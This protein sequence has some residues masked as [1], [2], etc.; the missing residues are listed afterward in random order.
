[1]I[2]YPHFET[3]C[4]HSLA[5]VFADEDLREEPYRQGSALIGE[6]YSFQVA[7]RSAVHTKVRI[8]ID[9]GLSC[10]ISVRSVGLAPSELPNY[11]D[12]DDYLLRTAPGLYPDPL[13]PLEEE[14]LKV[15]PHQWR[16]LWITVHLSGRV[17]PGIHDIHIGF[18]DESGQLGSESFRLEAI[19]AKLPEQKLIH[20]QWFYLD[21]LATWYDVDVF[22][23]AHWTIIES[24]L[25]NYVEYGM[26]MILT[27]LFTPPLE[28]LPGHERPTVQLVG[29]RTDRNRYV[30]D[31]S[32]L[33]RWIDLCCRKGIQYFEFSHLFT[34]WGAK[35]APKIMAE[36]NGEESRIFGWETDAA[37]EEYSQFLAQFI[38][39]LVHWIRSRGLEK[40]S[41]F[42]LSDEPGLNDLPSY[43]QASKMVRS[44]LEDL[45]ILDALSE[46]DF[47]STGLLTHPVVATGHIERFIENNTPNLWAYYCCNEY[48]EHLSNRFFNMPSS[49]TRMI[50][51]Q[52]YKFGIQGFLHWGYNHWYSQKS[53][54]PINPYQVTD[55][56][57]AFPSGD[58]FLVY[59][60][61]EGPVCSI[62]M[63]VMREAMQ[64]IRALQLLE[65][66]I[67][68]QETVRCLEQDM[69]RPITFKDYEKRS[70]WMIEMRERVNR[71]IKQYILG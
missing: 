50:G 37:G 28:M 7:Y 47:Y 71:M 45:P 35:H 36:V 49:R 68:K 33:E 32:R 5:K 62:R 54:K 31:F 29:V 30:F 48:R 23:E 40:R 20:T 8:S 12:H 25:T 67:G 2:H 53:L 1:M 59:P 38:P 70:D 17:T 43:T 55:A 65:G 13:Y 27:P 15:P 26:N 44:L 66:L 64:D 34:Q 4:I 6:Y 63:A 46:Y 14:S 22:S 41:Y 56:D 10:D 21:C 11:Q 39:E 58:A 52:L 69:D 57:M 16:S 24:Y 60:G 42:H 19:A 61:K 9:S 3:R 18:A 51:V